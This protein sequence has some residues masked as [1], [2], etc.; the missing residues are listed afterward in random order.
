[1]IAG[2]DRLA[3]DRTAVEAVGHA[4]TG[5]QITSES[6]CAEAIGLVTNAEVATSGIAARSQHEK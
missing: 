4:Q 5:R 2:V 6:V 3:I 1:V